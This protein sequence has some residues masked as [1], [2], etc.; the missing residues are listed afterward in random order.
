MSIDF[1]FIQHSRREITDTATNMLNGQ[2][3]YIEGSRAILKSLH[4]A[5]IDAQQPPFVKF[6]AIVSETDAVPSLAERG[7][8]SDNTKVRL[9]ADWAAAELWARETGEKAC[10]EALLWLE[11]NPI[12]L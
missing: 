3:P 11:C 1:D 10:R 2:Y 9:S 8:W 4:D 7:L 5:R 6:I 12:R